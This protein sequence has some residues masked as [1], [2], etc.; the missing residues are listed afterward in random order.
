MVKQSFRPYRNLAFALLIFLMIT[1][2]LFRISSTYS[3]FWQTW[4]EPA[5][6]ASGME[7]LDKRQY[8][9]ETLHP[10]LARVMSALGPYLDGI[11]SNNKEDMWDEG[12]TILHTNNAYERNLTLSRLGILPFFIIA[13]LVVALWAKE[14]GGVATSLLSVA[15]FTTTP[16]ILAHSGLATLDMACAS[17]VPA[18]LFAFDLWLNRP[19][20]LFSCLLGLTL[21]LAIVSKFSSVGF[22]LISIV[23]IGIIYIVNKLLNKFL[24]KNSTQDKATYKEEQNTHKFRQ[25]ILRL[26]ITILTCFM[27]FWA[28]YG[29]SYAPL[30]SSPEYSTK[31]KVL[32][33]R[34]VGSQGALHNLAYYAVEKVSIPAP[35]LVIGIGHLSARDKGG[36]TNYLFGDIRDKGWWY[37]YPIVI[38]FKTPIPSLI[39]IF[40]GIFFLL[41]KVVTQQGNLQMLTPLAG[42]IGV[43]IVGMLGSVNNGS[44]QML[45]IYPF[46]AILAGYGASKLLFLNDRFR[47]VRSAFLIVLLSWQFIS[48]A[49][50]HPD[51]IPY[52]N[53]L[54][55]N[56][57]EEITLDS[58]LDWGQDLKRL[59]ATLEKRGVKELSISYNGSK[60]INFDKLNLPPRQ[61][62]IPYQKTTG[63]IAISLYH[64]QLNDGFSWLKQYQPIEKVGKSIWLY[65]IDPK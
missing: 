50:A 25:W 52:F 2:G 1:I 12:D 44:R 5:S 18:A 60:G 31:A 38:F 21:G 11:R 34:I 6:V 3:V 65:Y 20:L 22:L 7:L 30:G 16:S 57:P 49:I 43:L 33:N 26:V 39:L 51:Y 9:Y 48:T 19:N 53:E 42:A 47:Y 61:Q 17:L 58:D 15:I 29:F 46:L 45:A 10:P 28:A 32:I 40:I 63:W 24:N 56:H 62:L 59:V 23:I 41:T 27:V 54:A 55:G 8:T 64:L 14:Y 36:G 35:E 4:D 13:S 37:F